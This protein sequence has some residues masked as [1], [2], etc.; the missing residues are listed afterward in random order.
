MNKKHWNTIDLD[1]TVPQPEIEVMIDDLFWLVVVGL[2]KSDC[3]AYA[4]F[5]IVQGVGSVGV[6][7][8]GCGR[9][10]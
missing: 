6:I 1:G 4:H 3:E 7:L 5:Y 10:L 9:M 2:K 8:T